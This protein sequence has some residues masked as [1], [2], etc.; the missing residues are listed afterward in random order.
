MLRI[1]C[2]YCQ[3]ARSEEEFSHAGEAHIPRPANPDAS[4]DARWGEYLH[5]RRNP[6]GP[7]REMWVHTAGC[8]RYF[9]VQRDTVSYEILATYAMGEL[10]ADG[11]E[12][13]AL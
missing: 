9:N 1:R 11:P 7:H 10:P 3:E 13:G 8:R 4:S 5:L 6:R 12:E 2:P